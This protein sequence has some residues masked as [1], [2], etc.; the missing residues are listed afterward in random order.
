MEN[1]VQR[2]VVLGNEEGIIA[3]INLLDKTEIPSDKKAT[4]PPAP[5]LLSLKEVHRE[6]VRKAETEVIYRA[7]ER[8]NWNA[9]KAAPMLN[10]SYKSMLNKIKE[11]GVNRWP[12]PKES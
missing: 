5:K 6:A 11:Y 3:E 1:L 8:A 9:K 2:Y 12:S 7:L 10:I 4:S